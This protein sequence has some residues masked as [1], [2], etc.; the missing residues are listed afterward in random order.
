MLIKGGFLD[1]PLG[2][3]GRSRLLDEAATLPKKGS[4]G[5]ARQPEIP[6]PHPASWWAARERRN[7]EH[8]PLTQTARER[9]EWEALSLNVRR[10]PLLPYRGALEELGVSPSEEI[11]G[12]PHGTTARA[13]GLIECLQSPPTKSGHP[14]YFLVIEDESGLLQATIFR[15]LYERQGEILHRE[16]AFLLEGRVEQTDKRGFAFLVERIESLREALAGA[17][18]PTPRV[19]PSA[20]AF[21]RAGRRNRRAG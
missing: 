9:M 13:A 19:T 16:G 6:L 12:L 8:L 11:K 5:S 20:G 2:D 15:A 4:S 1:A 18:V 7:V 10:H 3:A 17:A 21:L 14:V